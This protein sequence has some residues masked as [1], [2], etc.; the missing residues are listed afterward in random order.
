[1]SCHSDIT[2][3]LTCQRKPKFT[4]Q[5]HLQQHHEASILVTK[6]EQLHELLPLISLLLPFVWSPRGAL[7]S[8]SPCF[9]PHRGTQRAILQ[10]EV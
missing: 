7:K 2:L 5:L 1:M 4:I 10:V 6:D 9:T 8:H 3:Y